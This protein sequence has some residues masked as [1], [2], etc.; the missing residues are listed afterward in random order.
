V[1]TDPTTPTSR[2][3]EA[4]LLQ[5]QDLA[6]APLRVR[7]QWIEDAAAAV[8][9]SVAAGDLGDDGKSAA[10]HL[11]AALGAIVA[12][13]QRG[14]QGEKKPDSLVELDAIVR[15]LLSRAQLGLLRGLAAF[16]DDLVDERAPHR[17]ACVQARD[18][19]QEIARAVEKGTPTPPSALRRLKRVREAL[20]T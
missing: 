8:D 17:A 3:L 6:G 9:A 15:T 7:L 12:W 16:Y 13:S 19:L 5:V 4:V 2:A 20:K 14:S 1:T 10:L 11:R 18:A